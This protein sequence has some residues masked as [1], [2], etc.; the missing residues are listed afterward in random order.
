MQAFIFY[1]KLS[2]N[3]GISA[4]NLLVSVNSSI[5]LGGLLILS[6]ISSNYTDKL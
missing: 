1:F 4:M 5:F 6:P 2:I 3:T